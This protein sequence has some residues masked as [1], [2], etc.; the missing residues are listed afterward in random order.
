M[1]EYILNNSKKFKIKNLK[2]NFKINKKC[3]FTVDTK[4]DYEFLRKKFKKYGH[5]FSK[6]YK[7]K[8]I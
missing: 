4:E 5:K 8:K 2:F 1:N 6:Y 7:N 3:S